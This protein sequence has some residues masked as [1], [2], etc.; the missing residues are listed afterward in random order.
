MDPLTKKIVK[1]KKS[2]DIGSKI[3]KNRGCCSLCYLLVVVVVVP[4]MAVL[5]QTVMMAAAMSKLLLDRPS[6]SFPTFVHCLLPCLVYAFAL[7]FVDI[8][9]FQFKILVR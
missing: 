7:N 6:F 3:G 9:M 2:R 5:W 8:S 1:D 4:M